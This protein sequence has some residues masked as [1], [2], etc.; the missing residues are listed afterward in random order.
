MKNFIRSDFYEFIKIISKRLK[1]MNEFGY[2]FRTNLNSVKASRKTKLQTEVD[3]FLRKVIAE[4][5]DEIQIYPQV[6]VNAKIDNDYKKT[7][8]NDEEVADRI[9][10]VERELKGRG[11]L[12]IRP[13]GTE[14]LVRVMIEGIEIEKIQ[15]LAEDLAGLIAAKFPPEE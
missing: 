14:P 15:A 1:L 2:Q 8:M 5:C 4:L 12:L 13:S 7:Y 9:K 3:D 6:L 11:R 10:F